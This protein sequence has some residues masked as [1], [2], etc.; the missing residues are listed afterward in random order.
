MLPERQHFVLSLAEPLEIFICPKASARVAPDQFSQGGF[1]VTDENRKQL[2]RD[3]EDVAARLVRKAIVEDA[4]FQWAGCVTLHDQRRGSL[5]QVGFG[6]FR[7]ANEFDARTALADIRLEDERKIHSESRADFIERTQSRGQRVPHDQFRFR[8]E[9]RAGQKQ[10]LQSRH[11]GFAHHA[12]GENAG[13]RGGWHSQSAIFQRQPRAI[14]SDGRIEHP[15]GPE[16]PMPP[17]IESRCE[18]VKIKIHKRA[19]K[20]LQCGEQ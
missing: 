16:F 3:G 8:C 2:F 17:A 7:R 19:T 18:T 11:L 6:L 20:Q 10:F 15:G 4:G 5:S 12:A 14:D 9:L 13:V 1:P